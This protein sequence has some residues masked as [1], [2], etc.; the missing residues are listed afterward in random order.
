MMNDDDDRYKFFLP[1]TKI[2]LTELQD[3]GYGTRATSYE[4]AL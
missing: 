2:F 1:A 3:L 4:N